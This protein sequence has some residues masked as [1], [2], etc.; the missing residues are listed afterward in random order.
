MCGS[1][2]VFSPVNSDQVLS[3]VVFPPEPVSHDKRQVVGR[4]DASPNVLL[5][6]APP[7]RRAGGPRRSVTLVPHGFV[8]LNI[9]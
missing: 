6:N 5:V 9:R 2:E 4:Q 8:H 7:I 1:D 3:D